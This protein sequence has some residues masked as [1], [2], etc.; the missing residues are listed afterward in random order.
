MFESLMPI[1]LAAALLLWIL[2]H[3]GM[4]DIVGAV[5]E[6]IVAVITGVAKLAT[7]LIR[8]STEPAKPQP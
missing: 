5:F 7:Y 6:L 3:L 2:D 1:L 8:R 4:L